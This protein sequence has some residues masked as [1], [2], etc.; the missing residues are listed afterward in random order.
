M[1]LKGTLSLVIDLVFILVQTPGRYSFYGNADIANSAILFLL[2][3]AIFKA[4]CFN[5]Y[6]GQQ[7]WFLAREKHTTYNSVLSR[8]LRHV[9]KI[10]SDTSH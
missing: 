2:V 7:S 10:C 6:I 9:Y 8:F 1:S 3:S 4:F 5:E